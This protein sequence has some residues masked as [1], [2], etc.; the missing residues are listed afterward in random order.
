MIGSVTITETHE[1]LIMV[2]LARWVFHS[3]PSTVCL[4]RGVSHGVFLVDASRTGSVVSTKAGRWQWTA[5]EAVLGDVWLDGEASMLECTNYDGD[6]KGYKIQDRWS[7]YTR[8][9]WCSEWS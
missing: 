9:F 7:W 3:M 8:E 1:T 2:H 4:V 5:T 6:E